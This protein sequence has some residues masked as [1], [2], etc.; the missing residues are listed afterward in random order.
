MF[1]Y[2]YNALVLSRAGKPIYGMYGNIYDEVSFFGMLA[3][4][5]G[6]FS[7][8]KDSIEELLSFNKHCKIIFKEFGE[9]II[10]CM[11]TNANSIN[12]DIKFNYTIRQLHNQC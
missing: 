7:S 6:K 11:C 1:N 9:I 12:N 10:I 5:V 4:I 2:P 8:N 3:A